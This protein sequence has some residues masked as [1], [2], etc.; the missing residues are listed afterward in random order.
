MSNNNITIESTAVIVAEFAKIH[1]GYDKALEAAKKAVKALVES[2]KDNK[3]ELLK[4]LRKELVTA[5]KVPKQRVSEIFLALGIRERAA[6]VKNKIVIDEAIIAQLVELAE[7]LAEDNAN[8]ALR[9]A[10]SACLKAG[11]S[12]E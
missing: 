4:A 2:D 1:L 3:K 10:Y 12:A 9:R 7:Q 11:E 6:T 8:V 5:H